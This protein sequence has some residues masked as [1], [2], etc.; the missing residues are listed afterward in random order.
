MTGSERR[1]IV[2]VNDRGLTLGL[3][4]DDRWIVWGGADG[5]EHAASE[6][7]V[8]LLPLLERPYSEIQ[9]AVAGDGR[10][11][12]LLPVLVRRALSWPTPY[13][14]SRAIGWLE[15]GFP[16]AG[17]TDELAAIETNRTLPQALRDRARHLAR[18]V[19]D[20]EPTD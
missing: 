4:E 1:S 20:R 18:A 10:G 19:R 12:W 2:V 7:L 6:R 8:W 3:D 14:P 9:R 5:L 13:W 16:I 15:T 17:C 11:E